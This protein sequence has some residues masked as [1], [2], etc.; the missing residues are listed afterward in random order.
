M[1]SNT[2]ELLAVQAINNN[3]GVGGFGIYGD[4]NPD[5]IKAQNAKL[6]ALIEA[7]TAK[8]EHTD[9]TNTGATSGGTSGE[10]ST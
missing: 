5:A 10:T 7:L 6:Q 2:N 8:L 9:K 4:T 1:Y 3:N